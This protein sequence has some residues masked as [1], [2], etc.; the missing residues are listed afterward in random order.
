[1]DF[2]FGIFFDDYVRTDSIIAFMFILAFLN[3]TLYNTNIRGVQKAR[4]S[5]FQ[6]GQNDHNYCM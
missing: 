3:G 6:G 1:M 5:Q 4:R 2:I